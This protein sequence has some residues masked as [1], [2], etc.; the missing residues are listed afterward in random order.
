MVAPAGPEIRNLSVPL[1]RHQLVF[2]VPPPLITVAVP[3]PTGSGVTVKA[4]AR[5]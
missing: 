4:L 1:T 3:V 5:P 2:G